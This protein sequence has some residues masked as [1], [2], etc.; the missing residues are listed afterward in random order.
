MFSLVKRIVAKPIK[1][2]LKSTGHYIVGGASIHGAPEHFGAIMFSRKLAQFDY[3]YDKIQSVEGDVIESGIWWGYGLL[4]H[5]RFARQGNIK[6]NIIGFDSFQGHSTPHKKDLKGG[7]FAHPGTAF[8]ITEI[9]VWKTLSM[10]TEQTVDKL[11]ESVSIVSGWMQETMPQFKSQNPD[12]KIALVHCDPDIYEPVFVTL[13]NV[14]GNLVPGG[15]VAI[16]RMNNP[17]YMGKTEAVKDFLASISDN[18][19]VLESFK[20]HELETNI[21]QDFYYITKQER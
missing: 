8:A 16:G 7:K 1:S 12:R 13:T 11:R 5:L 19:Y 18:S 20:I 17:E 15:I 14:W 2:Y 10:G 6:R 3:F 4:A 9:D 21:S